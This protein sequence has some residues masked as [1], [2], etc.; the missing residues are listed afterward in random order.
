[1]TIPAHFDADWQQQ[2]FSCSLWS[3]WKKTKYKNGVDEMT[4]S[5]NYQMAKTEDTNSNLQLVET[6]SHEL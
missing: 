2:L 4:S 1:M 3:S 6:S 5:S